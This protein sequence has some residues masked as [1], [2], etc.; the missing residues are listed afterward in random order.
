MCSDRI[1]LLHAAMTSNY[2]KHL[3]VFCA[4]RGRGY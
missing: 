2:S 1:E 3:L 4:K